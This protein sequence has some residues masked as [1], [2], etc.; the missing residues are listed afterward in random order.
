ME[1]LSNR[2]MLY[3]GML[4]GMGVGVEDLKHIQNLIDAEEKGLLL[5][6]PC[7]V[8]DTVYHEKKYATWLRGVNEYQIT[9]II[10]SQNKKGIWTKK[11]R[12]MM[13]LNGKTT[14]TS[15]DFSFEDIGKT[16]FLT[17]E[18]AESALEKMK[19]GSNEV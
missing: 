19:G 6:L 10:V 3:C 15:V 4:A 5:R 9:N 7:K 13:L 18:E 11:Y 16:V 1:R 12:A 2:W 8:G 17:K 14:T